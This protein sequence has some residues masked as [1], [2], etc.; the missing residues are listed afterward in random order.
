MKS[1][2]LFVVHA[3]TESVMEETLTG[4]L[5]ILSCCTKFLLVKIKKAVKRNGLQS[6]RSRGPS[7]SIGRFIMYSSQQIDMPSNVDSCDIWLL[8]HTG[9]YRQF[10]SPTVAV[11]HDMVTLHF[12]D[13]IQK[14]RIESFRRHCERLVKQRL[15]VANDPRR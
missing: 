15:F 4:Y 7:K 13:V 1:K 8:P 9:V 12:H 6:Y 2:A 5:S 3:G 14:K 11:V 10:D